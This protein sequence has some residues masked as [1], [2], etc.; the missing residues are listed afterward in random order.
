MPN[1]IEDAVFEA[2]REDISV[3][4]YLETMFL[5]SVEPVF[6][7][8]TKCKNERGMAIRIESLI[9]NMFRDIL[10]NNASLES[11]ILFE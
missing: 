10:L 9:A 8:C 7:E 3:L 2:N 11:K 1:D 5:T 6:K 4:Y